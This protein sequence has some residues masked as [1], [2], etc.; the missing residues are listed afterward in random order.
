[1]IK[2]LGSLTINKEYIYYNIDCVL[3]EFLSLRCLSNIFKKKLKLFYYQKGQKS[4]ADKHYMHVS[5]IL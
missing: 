1:M 3:S 4:L 5:R 2:R